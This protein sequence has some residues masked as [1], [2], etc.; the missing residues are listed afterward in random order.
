MVW[1]R[2]LA[3]LFLPGM[4]F[5]QTSSSQL[6]LILNSRWNV[7]DAGINKDGQYFIISSLAEEDKLFLWHP[8]IAAINEVKWPG[9]V[10]QQAFWTQSGNLIVASEDR[11]FEVR[12]NKIIPLMTDRDIQAYDPKLNHTENLLLF[13]G[14][15]PNQSEAGLF[16]FDFVYQNLNQFEGTEGCRHA[17]WSPSDELI[18][19]TT[20]ENNKQILKLFHW[21]AKPYAIIQND[22]LDF[23]QAI[24]SDSDYR[25]FALAS[26]KKQSYIINVRKD[27]SKPEIVWQAKKSLHLLH[28]LSEQNKILAI[29]ETMDGH[30]QLISIDLTEHYPIYPI[31]P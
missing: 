2:L 14:R 23:I 10:P 25:L 12:Q 15:R 7:Q 28:Y 16:T 11:F 6:E 24:W 18:V 22:S 21:Y 9:M 17:S 20:I 29:E 13:R 4:L 27:G 5:S 30:K 1:M 31:K 8:E 3:I 26:G 19:C